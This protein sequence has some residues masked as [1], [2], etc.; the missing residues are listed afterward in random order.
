MKFICSAKASVW[1]WI[2]KCV[3]YQKTTT[4]AIIQSHNAG[5]KRRQKQHENTIS[6]FAE[7][8]QVDICSNRNRIRLY[9]LYLRRDCSIV[10]IHNLLD[11]MKRRCYHSDGRIHRSDHRRA[12][13]PIDNLFWNMFLEGFV[14]GTASGHRVGTLASAVWPPDG[15]EAWLQV[16]GQARPHTAG[17]RSLPQTSFSLI[18]GSNLL[19][20]MCAIETKF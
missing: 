6:I 9:N 18:H 16:I 20:S 8:L 5:S 2:L 4:N 1:L 19:P 14:I 15:Q 13:F 7:Q 12:L 3:T 17:K 11:N 10:Y